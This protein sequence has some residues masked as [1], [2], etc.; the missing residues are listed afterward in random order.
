[1][2]QFIIILS[3]SI[4]KHSGMVASPSVIRKKDI[5]ID[6]TQPAEIIPDT[7]EDKEE[8]DK[9]GPGD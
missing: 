4:Y 9:D 6:T 1:M 7:P 3:D 8:L 5:H 2:N